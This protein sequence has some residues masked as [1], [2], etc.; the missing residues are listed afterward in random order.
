MSLSASPAPRHILPRASLTEGRRVY[1]IRLRK[2][3]WLLN[4]WV[5]RIDRRPVRTTNGED[6]V[7]FGRMP[8]G[9]IHHLSWN[10]SSTVEALTLIPG[11]RDKVTGASAVEVTGM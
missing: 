2:R 8:R 3:R 1:L 10:A 4:T 9:R 5:R 7:V 6:V 11:N